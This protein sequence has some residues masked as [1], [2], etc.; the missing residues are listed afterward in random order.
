MDSALVNRCEGSPAALLAAVLAARLALGRVRR[1]RGE[2]PTGAEGEFIEAGEADYQVQLTRLL[3][4]AAA[5]RR[6]ISCAAR[7]PLPADE[8]YLGVFLRIEN[9]GD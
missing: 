5:A 7:P 8:A 1:R 4:P 2:A 3:N 6:R 9:D